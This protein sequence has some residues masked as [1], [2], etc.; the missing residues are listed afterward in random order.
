M[1]IEENLALAY[2]RSAKGNPFSRISQKDK[3]LFRERLA[4]L[5]SLIHI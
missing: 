1:T 4:L 5:L 2:L 3:A